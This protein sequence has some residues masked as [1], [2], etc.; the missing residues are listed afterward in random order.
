MN[1]SKHK[2]DQGDSIPPPC[3]RSAHVQHLKTSPPLPPLPAPS[4]PSAASV[5]IFPNSIFVGSGSSLHPS[6]AP[7]RPH[8]SG[9]CPASPP[10]LLQTGA[11]PGRPTTE[12]GPRGQQGHRF[13]QDL[14]GS[15]TSRCGGG[16]A[17]GGGGVGA[18]R[19]GRG[20]HLGRR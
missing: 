9:I 11:V 12:S 10:K 6:R 14:E 20:V 13:T 2:R 8:T 5:K 17:A 19:G 16:S 4:T 3:H 18:A 7:E 1:A 15:V